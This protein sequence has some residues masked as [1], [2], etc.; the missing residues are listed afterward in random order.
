MNKETEIENEIIEKTETEKNE[1]EVKKEINESVFELKL[2][3]IIE[4]IA[5]TNQEFNENIYFIDYIDE[6]VLELIHISTLTKATIKINEFGLFTDESIK[7]VILHSR[8]SEEGYAK[9]NGLL[10]H[11]WVEVHIGGDYPDIFVGEISN[12]EEDMIEIKK[13]PY[14]G[15]LLYIDFAYK[16][17]PKH[18]PIQS[19]TVKEKPKDIEENN[20]FEEVDESLIQEKASLDVSESG[21]MVINMPENAVA[22]ENILKELN[23]RYKD[24][25][26]ITF[27]DEEEY[28]ERVE[29]SEKEKKYS[30]ETQVNDFMDELL[31]TIPNNKRTNEVM[32][33]IHRLIERYKQL[34]YNFSIFDENGNVTE[35]VQKGPDYKPLVEKLNNMEFNFGWIIPVVSQ[36]RRLF[37]GNFDKGIFIEDVINADLKNDI[38]EHK[39]LISNYKTSVNNRYSELYRK[40]DENL[41]NPFVPMTNKDAYD[42]K[43]RNMRMTEE[44]DEIL[45][46]ESNFLVELRKI[47]SEFHAIVDNFDSFESTIENDVKSKD[48]KRK[49]FAI[50][51]YNFGLETNDSVLT[52]SGRTVFFKSKL[53]GDDLISLKSLIFMPELMVKYSAIT[54]PET[55]ILNKVNLHQNVFSH[56]KLF[57]KKTEIENKI[58]DNFDNELDYGTQEENF[59]IKNILNYTIDENLHSSSD[60]FKKFL[61]VIIPTKRNIIKFMKKN[62]KNKMSMVDVIK[63]LEPFSI[64]SDDISYSD[65]KELRHFIKTQIEEYN[66]NIEKKR[67]LFKK[68][69][70]NISDDIEMNKIQKLIFDERE[71]ME[72]FRDGY[73]MEKVDFKDFTSS[74]LLSKLIKID[75]C[76]LISN[77]LITMTIKN[78]TTPMD[79]LQT[80]EPA[81]LDDMSNF[82]KIK[83]GDCTRR[84]LTKKYTSMKDLQNDQYKEILYYDKEFDDTPYH[85]LDLYKNE[86]KTMDDEMF[87]EFLIESLNSKHGIDGEEAEEL[88]QTL[89]EEKKQIRDGEYAVLQIKPKLPPSVD[90]SELT[91]EEKKQIEIEENAREKTGYYYRLKDQWIYDANIDPEVFIDSKTLFCN[92][93]S[94]CYSNENSLGQSLCQDNKNAKKRLDD[95][96][97]SR[98][99][100]EFDNRINLSLNEIQEKVKAQLTKDFKRINSIM[101]IK[102]NQKNSMNNFALELSKGYLETDIVISKH[103]KLRDCILEQTDFVKKQT[104]ILRFVDLFC[105]EPFQE[106]ELKEH[107]YWYYCKDTNTKLMPICYILLAQAFVNGTY[108]EKLEELCSSV[109]RLSEDQDSI[110]DQH[111]GYELRKRD[112]INEDEYT[113]EGFKVTRHDLLEEELEMKIS[114]ALNK[115]VF[116]NKENEIIFNITD[117]ICSNIG[118]NTDSIKD[119]VINTSIDILNTI[120]SKQV[121][122]NFM[123]EKEKSSDKPYLQY[124]IYKNRIMFWIISA[125]IVIGVQTTDEAI[126]VKKTFPGCVRSLSGYPVTGIEDTN[127][128]KYIACV[129]KQ[130][131]KSIKPWDSIAKI[132][133]EVYVT[134]ITEIIST[135][136]LARNDVEQRILKKREYLKE[137]PITEIPEENDVKK[138]T[139]FLPPIVPYKIGTIRSV[140]KEREKELIDEMRQ[141]KK[142][143]HESFYVVKDKSLIYGYGF[144][145][146]INN[147][148]A[149]KEPLLKTVSNDPFVDNA[150]CNENNNKVINYFIKEND[151]I[152]KVINA[153]NYLYDFIKEMKQIEKGKILYHPEFTGIKYPSITE[154]ITDEIIYDT[155]IKYCNLDNDEQEIPQEFLHIF[156]EKIPDFPVKG[157]LLDKMEF[158]KKEG[159]HFKE[160]DMF[161]FV[162]IL[163]KKKIVTVDHNLEYDEKSVLYDLLKRI[164]EKENTVIDTV[165]RGHIIKLLDTY[166]QKQ[167]INESKELNNFKD[168]LYNANEKLYYAIVDFFDENGNLDDKQFDKLQ[169]Y[170][171]SVT[172]TDLNDKDSIYNVVNFIKKSIYNMTKLY[173]NMILFK[174]KPNKVP[175]HWNISRNHRFDIQKKIDNY[176]QFLDKF[177]NSSI[178]SILVDVNNNLNDLYMFINKLPIHMYFEKNDETFYSLFDK[179]C[180]YFMFV[181]FW[182]STIYDYIICANDPQHINNDLQEKKDDR[183]SNNKKNTDVSQQLSSVN[184]ND[185]NLIEMDI[186]Q[187][188]QM[189]LKDKVALLLL[190][191]I[192]LEKQDR[193]VLSSYEEISKKAYRE[194]TVEKE[195]RINMFGE[196]TDKFERKLLEELQNFKI[197]EFNIALQKSNY[198]YDGNVYDAERE[199][200]QLN[201]V[202]IDPFDGMTDFENTEER[203][204]ISHLGEDFMD[205]DPDGEYNDN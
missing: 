59:F 150:C 203:F 133:E 78:L 173:P 205:G 20:D 10:P 74:E 88:A 145:E 113:S 38:D 9:Q 40:L 103:I 5:P 25:S 30:I 164:D 71:Y 185:E 76:S 36:K 199:G 67:E 48:S 134:R 19:I 163:S 132:K 155:I 175:E 8:N 190:T 27:G 116:E 17:L 179:E 194:K 92:I 87:K 80:F 165:F 46:S 75:S 3:D 109:G 131:K 68:Y 188:N 146:L 193:L 37:N 101:R 187:G 156:S 33:K 72:M 161:E 196:I 52:K 45:D 151:N 7:S 43:L 24:A 114:K 86:R 81:K 162:K 12:L 97:R 125:C 41:L 31:S 70:S 65:F 49:K 93:K 139:S 22:D 137:Y 34:R 96:T 122:D 14:S 42:F 180:I 119:F 77:I 18:I 79:L 143:Q 192:G 183:I 32:E 121:Y 98:M 35:Q 21:E 198:V 129:L 13:Y 28:D 181:Y 94:N 147:I 16:G 64:Y 99:V 204:N 26:E 69:L 54:L 201:Q 166:D 62:I 50:Q 23:K 138:W 85:L 2:G 100:K 189:D 135:K 47:E 107:Q 140:T 83:L 127:N 171:L 177:S 202:E 170:L 89:I 160:N 144:V 130:I 95:L 58:I 153:S 66:D 111:S 11:K 200:L 115:P 182:Y 191:F 184:F 90:E 57:N 167:M 117:T 108:N 136:L 172:D 197:G 4:V 82:E 1:E 118:V 51:R 56:F 157:S 102:E 141:G 53:T 84:Y 159:K 152:K 15:T 158:L 60:K 168:F 106:A 63:D 39:T 169:D 186:L 149:K 29:L 61:N 176:W 154:T 104:D 124:E 6:T 174:G 73:K 195:E 55:T 44:N 91:K 110:V 142:S 148:I 105:R 120:E 128:I 112:Y 126:K 178:N 123:K